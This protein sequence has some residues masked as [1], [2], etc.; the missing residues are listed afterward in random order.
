[1]N[2]SSTVLGH[3]LET[4]EGHVRTPKES[5]KVGTHPLVVVNQL[6]LGEGIVITQRNIASRA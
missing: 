6:P 3:P 5:G 1:M 2:A 4:T